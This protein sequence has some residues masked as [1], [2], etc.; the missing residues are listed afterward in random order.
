MDGSLL[1][2]QHRFCKEHAGIGRRDGRF[3]QPRNR[4]FGAGGTIETKRDAV[5][6]APCGGPFIAKDSVREVAASGLHDHRQ[7]ALNDGCGPGRYRA[8]GASDM[9]GYVQGVGCGIGFA[10]VSGDRGHDAKGVVTLRE[11]RATPLNGCGEGER[12]VLPRSHDARVLMG[13]GRGD[14]RAALTPGSVEGDGRVR[15]R[16]PRCDSRILQADANGVRRSGNHLRGDIVPQVLDGELGHSGNSARVYFCKVDRVVA[17]FDRRGDLAPHGV[18]VPAIEKDE[19]GMFGDGGHPCGPVLIFGAVRR[20]LGLLFQQGGVVARADGGDF[21]P[22]GIVEL[23][24]LDK[25]RGEVPVERSLASEAGAADQDKVAAELPQEAPAKIS[26]E[27]AVQ[28]FERLRV[29][30]VD[31][32][33][34]VTA[35]LGAERHNGAEL[36][37]Y[38]PVEVS[39]QIV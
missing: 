19:V 26:G 22:G 27:R 28:L 14:Y 15:L 20:G 11:R 35:V 12:D 18:V 30:Q 24:A 17:D 37:R 6:L 7:V 31:G 10:V 13:I 36:G 25:G 23:E 21:D 32:A 33:R 16:P 9:H 8:L 34:A 38:S 5:A 3:D 4:A 29:G 1:S 2:R 39:D